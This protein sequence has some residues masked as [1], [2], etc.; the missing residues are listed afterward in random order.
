GSGT[1]VTLTYSY[2][3][4]LDGRL[5]GSLSASTLRAIVQEA[6]GRW[7]SVAPINFVEV[8]DSGPAPSDTNYSAAGQPQIRFGHR[9]IDGAFNILAYGYYPGSSGLA[10]D[11]QFDS[12]E[13]WTSTG[14]GRS[15]VDLLE[16]ATHE[17]GH[18]LGLAHESMPANGG[19]QAIMNPF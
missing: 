4:L 10:G 6:L 11:I 8:A 1:P 14:A 16:V 19:Q 5:G 15:G 17:I 7:A 18:A 12:N 3:N 2:S 13:A 9:P